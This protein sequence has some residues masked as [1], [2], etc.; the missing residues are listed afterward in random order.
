MRNRFGRAAL[1]LLALG[2]P[3][4]LAQIGPRYAVDIKADPGGV[5]QPGRVELAGP[6]LA[7]IRYQ[8]LA[9]LAV[10][11]DA[12]AYSAEAVQHWP[13]ADVLVMT[14]ASAGRYGGLAP[15][16]TLHG[17]HVVLPEPTAGPTVPPMPVGSGPRW[18]PM[19]TWD[20]LHVRKGRTRLRV[21]AMPGQPGT[22]HVA[23][24]VLELGNGRVS[25]RLYLSCE[26]LADADWRTLPDRL[27][28]A[29]LALAPLQQAL[30]LLPLRRSAPAPI[31]VALTPAGYAFTAIRR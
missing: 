27:P 8:G 11:A 10:G 12:D 20:A 14:P 21:T 16:S 6:G 26:P 31:P 1:L 28:G 24:F 2:C 15:L 29:D 17:L 18:Y 22:A 4:V 5:A 23:G 19:H 30:Q 13:A 25:Y 9:I 3:V 7:L